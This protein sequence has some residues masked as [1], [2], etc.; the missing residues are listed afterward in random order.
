MNTDIESIT[1]QE[2][3]AA[4]AVVDAPTGNN[5]PNTTPSG[6]INSSNFLSQLTHTGYTIRMKLPF[7]A[8]KGPSP[9]F[10]FKVDP[11]A[12]VPFNKYAWYPEKSETK[13]VNTFDKLTP[14]VVKQL[15]CITYNDAICRFDGVESPQSRF[16]RAARFRRYNMVYSLRFSYQFSGTGLFAVIPLKALPYNTVPLANQ[17]IGGPT[18]SANMFNSY[19]LADGSKTREIKFSFPW[20]YPFKYKDLNLDLALA[21]PESVQTY[22][23]YPENWF[24]LYARGSF[25]APD[26]VQYIDIMVDHALTDYEFIEPYYPHQGMFLARPPIITSDDKSVY[27]AYVNYSTPKAIL[28]EEEEKETEFR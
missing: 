4:P 10:A 20:E 25:V 19:A 26:N 3:A 2:A 27:F 12:Y 28:E 22:P 14:K 15:S 6:H 18:V 5:T 24:I 7:L 11:I 17:V 8:D 13:D 23:F 1:T 21:D 16:A 9:I